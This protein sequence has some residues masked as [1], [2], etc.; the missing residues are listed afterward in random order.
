MENGSRDHGRRDH[1]DR[2]RERG[3][4]QNDD[5]NLLR[6]EEYNKLNF[7]KQINDYRAMESFVLED[8]HNFSE[9]MC[10]VSDISQR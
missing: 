8:A 2:E 4:A 9:W 10:R 5:E 1:R 3:L 6:T 7:N